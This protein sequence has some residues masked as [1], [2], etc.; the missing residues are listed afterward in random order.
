VTFG[1][2]AVVVVFL[3]EKN[4]MMVAMVIVIRLDIIDSLNNCPLDDDWYWVFVFLLL[5]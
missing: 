4:R 1:S 3:R 5:L 2:C